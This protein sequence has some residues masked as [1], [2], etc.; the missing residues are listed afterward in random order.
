M[1]NHFYTL[2]LMLAASWLCLPD[3]QAQC[4]S[5][6]GALSSPAT[7]HSCENAGISVSSDG[8]V[9]LDADDILRFVAYTG[10]A[11]NAGTALA[12][13]VDGN[14]AYQAS[15]LNNSPFK[16]AVVVGNN[17]GGNID[18]SDPCLSVS[19]AS[20]VIID[21]A[22]VVTATG[23]T[24]TCITTSV[25]MVASTTAPNPQFFWSN[26]V[27]G[28][29]ALV[30]VPGTFC[31]TVSDANG[32]T[33]EACA[34][35]AQDVAAPIA[36]PVP[37]AVLSCGQPAT[38]SPGNSSSGP[39]FVYTWTGPNGFS[40]SVLNPIVQFP[41][42]F[43]LIVTDATNG[44]TATG[45][46]TVTGSVSGPIATTVV[47]NVTCFGANDADVNL[48][49]SGGSGNYTYTW[50]GPN[51]FS[52]N[53]QNLTNVGP[54][55]YVVTVT[56]AAGCSTLKTVVV[57]QPTQLVVTDLQFT[58][59]PCGGNLL[60]GTAS[61]GV[62]PYSYL[63]SNF[64]T[65][66][67]IQNVTDGEYI[68]IVTD[69]NGCTA[70]DTLVVI[71][72]GNGGGS[73]DCSY[74]EGYVRRD[75]N[76]NCSYQNGEPGLAGWLVKAAGQETFYGTTNALGYFKFSALPGTYQVS[77]VATSGL[78]NPC[79]PP[80]SV[81]LSTPNTTQNVGNLMVKEAYQCPLLYVN[82]APFNLRRC[83]SNNTYSVYYCNQGNE[84]ATNAYVVI[85][86]DSLFTIENTTLPYVDLGN[87]QYR[88]DIGLIPQNDCGYFYIK[89]KVSC[90][91]VLGE[92][93]C[94]SAHIYPDGNCIP[95]DPN[96][97]GSLLHL[98]SECNSSDSLRFI[99]KNIGTG[100]MTDPVAYIVIEDHVMLMQATGDPLG[101]GDSVI[102]A[103]PANGATWRVEAAQAEYAPTLSVPILSVEGCGNSA[104]FTTGVVNQFPLNENDPWIDEDCTV[105]TGSFDPNDKQGFPNGYGDKHYIKP[106]TELEYMVRFQN[107][108]TDTAFTVVIVDT[109]SSLL[110]VGSLR[111]GVSSHLYTYEVYGAGILRVTYNNILLPDS[112]VNEPASHGFIRFRIQPRADAPLESVIENSAAIYF[113]FNDPVITNRTWHR[114]GIGF[115]ATVGSFEPF[116][117][118][119]IDVQVMPNPSDGDAL[120]Q[121]NG[122]SDGGTLRL[123]I[124]DLNGRILLEQTGTGDQIQVHARGWASGTY[125]YELYQENTYLG[126]G[127][128]MVR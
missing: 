12:Q 112:F 82:I 15:F 103:V 114:L 46:V 119:N 3:L 118:R 121:V 31:V 98:R 83:F 21:P 50:T 105:V 28:A 86:L 39:Q 58:I 69:A 6:A 8:N 89:G 91:A 41:G 1:K 81:T 63:W 64:S 101:S 44:C 106:G 49:I 42:T 74:I 32:C 97:D 40:S 23:G 72:A 104:T 88:F 14:F 22:P 4:T 113:D 17:L 61:G 20:T 55:I 117:K 10:A 60:K 43:T 9:V 78:W 95:P 94:S 66:P 52:V 99:L 54:G 51:G 5:A 92:V 53:T 80:A 33:S 115:L 70:T 48:S 93:L 96:W 85:T 57:T 65:T 110:D 59:N 120:F 19:P 16:I 26:G 75:D 126:A 124:R 84:D 30:N 71:G 67:V 68:L 128:V 100:D 107:T 79:T 56:D 25:A 111:M 87:H 29:T 109:L 13:S 108:G 18:W 76:L 36:N 11:P 2:L 38:L 116:G 102:I 90:D 24:L 47:N 27:I 35:V 77:A 45:I 34:T 73:G 7:F 127:K 37:T 123:R 122:L 125:L 62:P